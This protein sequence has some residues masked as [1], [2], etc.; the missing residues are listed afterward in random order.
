M[1]YWS[2]K[3]A[4][5]V[6]WFSIILYPAFFN[7]LLK[8]YGVRDSIR[9]AVGIAFAIGLSVMLLPTINFIEDIHCRHFHHAPCDEVDGQLP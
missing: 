9:I 3:V 8:N 2:F 4:S 5:T 6:M 7:Q 1:I